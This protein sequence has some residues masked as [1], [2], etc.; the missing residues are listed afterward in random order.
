MDYKLAVIIPAYNE[1]KA[2]AGVVKSIN[3]LDM[4]SQCA[5]SIVV[6][7]DC[8][9]DKTAAI[10]SGLHCTLLS[11]PVNVGIGGAVQTGYKFAYD[12][13]FDYAMQVDGD[14]QHPASEIPKLVHAINTSNKDVVIG[15]RFIEKGGFVSTYLRRLGIAY[16]RH[17]LR[18]FTSQV[19]TDSTS[20]FRIIN[21]RTLAIV[22]NSYPDEYPEPESIIL[23]SRH[24]LR[25][26]E[27]PVVMHERQGGQ[28]SIRAFASLYYMFKVT[29]AIFFTYLR[30]RNKKIKQPL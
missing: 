16:F 19:F 2:I 10:V 20:G 28:S 27:V 3:A 18:L 21:R 4:C 23:Y 1:E 6:V 17:L 22:S 14:G 5:L 8:S 13:D 24:R 15:S 9:K 26:G 25:I 29:F 11:L 7:N 30:L 12:N